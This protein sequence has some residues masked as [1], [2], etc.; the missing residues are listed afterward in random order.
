M[1]VPL[2][3]AIFFEPPRI[4][5]FFD[6]LSRFELSGVDC[7]YFGPLHSVYDIRS[8]VFLWL[9][10]S[11]LIFASYSASKKMRVLVE[12]LESLLHVTHFSR[13]I[14]HRKMNRL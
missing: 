2:L 6:F 8:V 11:R 9:S 14:N 12:E 3:P 4:R 10:V 7:D 5:T 13:I 1:F